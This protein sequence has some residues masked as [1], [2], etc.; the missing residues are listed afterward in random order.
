MYILSNIFKTGEN[1]FV[2]L[3]KKSENNLGMIYYLRNIKIHTQYS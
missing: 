3:Q 2:A 1:V